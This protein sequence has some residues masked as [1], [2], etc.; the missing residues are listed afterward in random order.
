M[1]DAGLSL[2]RINDMAIQL[3]IST[4]LFPQMALDELLSTAATAG[5]NG[6]ELG[7]LG[8]TA[9]DIQTNLTPLM[10]NQATFKAAGMQVAVLGTSIA[11]H[12]KGARARDA[13]EALRLAID[14]AAELQCPIVTAFG[15]AIPSGETSGYAYNRIAEHLREVALLAAVKGVRVAIRNGGSFASAASIWQLLENTG[16]DSIGS[17]WDSVAGE[18]AGE[19]PTQAVP[20]LGRRLAY[21]QCA[22][23]AAGVELT[24]LGT[25]RMQ[26]KQLVERLLGISYSGWLGYSLPL[27][28]SLANL[29]AKVE[30]PAAAEKLRTWLGLIKPP[31][32]VPAPAAA[33][34]AP[35][36]ADA[37]KVEPTPTPAS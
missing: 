9:R 33:K 8:H 7:R 1:P 18:I 11:L 37:P 29:D 12:H 30:L 17:A 16:H 22:D 31:E 32:A 26:N 27:G 14:C 35:A 10:R 3:S 23:C 20:L 28:V 21:V 25:G 4:N 6:V 13:M 15:F 24:A 5:F 2:E 36:K 19:P 34:P